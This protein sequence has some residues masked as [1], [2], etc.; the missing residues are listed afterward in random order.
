[1][2]I[3]GYTAGAVAA[4]AAVVSGE[5]GLLRTG[6]FRRRAYWAAMAIVFAFQVPV[7]GYLTSL[8]HPVVRYD[9]RHFAGVRFPFSIP[10]ED[11][12]YGFALVTLSMALWERAG[13]A[14]RPLHLGRF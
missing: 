14:S 2:R 9:A 5:L 13:Q 1:M 7:D 4:A 11:W 10:V 12:L 3:G 8:A 6:I